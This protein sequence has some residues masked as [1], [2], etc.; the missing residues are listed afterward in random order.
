MI[1][2]SAKLIEQSRLFAVYY[3]E[4]TN[5]KIPGQN[6]ADTMLHLP[7]S[8]CLCLT[9]KYFLH[10]SQ[11]KKKGIRMLFL[12]YLVCFSLRCSHHLE[13]GGDILASDVFERTVNSE[14]NGDPRGHQL[15]A[16]MTLKPIYSR[17]HYSYVSR[18]S[19]S[20]AAVYQ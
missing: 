2:H 9:L 15:K 17:G 1:L 12:V 7:D 11:K 3:K 14:R 6:R 16:K 4:R 5:G 13:D 8:V 20:F 19:L 10:I 18:Q